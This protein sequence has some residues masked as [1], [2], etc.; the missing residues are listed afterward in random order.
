MSMRPTRDPWVTVLYVGT[1]AVAGVSGICAL[2]ALATG[3]PLQ[4]GVAA[5]L[6]GA[7]WIAADF[8]ERTV[9]RGQVRF[10]RRHAVMA[11]RHAPTYRPSRVVYAGRCEHFSRSTP[12]VTSKLAA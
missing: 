4:F 12:R 10:A 1:V 11:V 6:F 9:A 2:A 5:A 7:G 3:S 8:I